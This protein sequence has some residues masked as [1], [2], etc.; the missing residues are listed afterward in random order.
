MNNTLLYSLVMLIAGLGIPVMATI[1]SELG[2]KLQSPALAATIFFVVG[3]IIAAA[4]LLITQGVPAKLHVP[5][6][7]WYFYFGGYFVLFY[8]LTIA[9]AAPNFGISNA[10]AFVVLGQLIA[11]SL[12]DHFGFLGTT[13][14]ALS[15]KRV[16][17]LVV[18]AIGVFMVL[19]K[20][21]D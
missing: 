21:P 6:T 19:S 16:I 11:M 17:G 9:W 2:I 10:V 12:I 7:P 18:M 15:S 13:Q 5:E 8:V 4:F 3:S 1:N 14:Y 20:V